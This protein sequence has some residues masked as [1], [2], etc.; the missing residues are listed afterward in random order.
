MA[1]VP[2]LFVGVLLT[3]A[4][5]FAQRPARTPDMFF[6]P[7]WEPVVYEMLQLAGV[8]GED[9]VYDL[10]SGDGRIVV[11][12]AQKYGARGV[13]IEID[14]RLVAISR[15]VAREAEVSDKVTFIEGDLFTADISGA[16]VVT[17][18]LSTSVNRQLE[19]KLKRELRPGTRIV[20]HQ[21]RI[22]NW[23]PERTVKAEG[24]GTELFLWTIPAR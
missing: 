6:A 22:G 7:T 9:V 1:S 14:P 17:L 3:G 15:Q 8:K 10:G 13:G 24:D 11:L 18:Y 19:A 23:S 12:A 21:F 2:S 20:S 4:V 5:V 16:T